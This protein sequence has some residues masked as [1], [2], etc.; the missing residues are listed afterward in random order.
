MIWEC[1]VADFGDAAGEGHARQTTAPFER[2]FA[3]RSNWKTVN[4]VR[5][6]QI[7]CWFRITTSDC[8]CSFFEFVFNIHVRYCIRE[9]V[10]CQLDVA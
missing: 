3:D 7:T 2:T 4:C 10:K 1:Q 5:D 8:R 6:D 9:L